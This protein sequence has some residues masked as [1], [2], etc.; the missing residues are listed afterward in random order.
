[1]FKPLHIGKDG[2]LLSIY[3]GKHK[4][5]YFSLTTQEPI[6]GGLKSSI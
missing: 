2:L 4:F 6:P 3:I 5:D 1:M